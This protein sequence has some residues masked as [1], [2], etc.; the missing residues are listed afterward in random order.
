MRYNKCKCGSFEHFGSGMNPSPCDACKKCGTT[1]EGLPPVPHE[2]TFIEKVQTDEGEKK[3]SRCKWC[4]KT[5][6]QIERME[7]E[8]NERDIQSSRRMP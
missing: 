4:Y 1:A 7:K 2:F 3:L 6:S 5:K 8:K